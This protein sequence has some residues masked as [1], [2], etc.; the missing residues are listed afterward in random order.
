MKGLF[1]RGSDGDCHDG[2]KNAMRRSVRIRSGAFQLEKRAMN[3]ET[4]L[5]KTD[6]FVYG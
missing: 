6:P 3:F 4:Y 5:K 1:P 2:G